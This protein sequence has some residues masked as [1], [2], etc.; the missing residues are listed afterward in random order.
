VGVGLA[1]AQQ[2][3]VDFEG[4][5]LWNQEKSIV[6]VQVEHI[7]SVENLEEILDVPGVDG[8]IVGP[9]DLSGSLGVPGQFQHPDVV[10]A[11]QRIKK[12]TREKNAL[13]GFHVVQPDPASFAEK[14]QEGYRFIAVGLDILYL[15]NACRNTLTACKSKGKPH[16]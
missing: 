6:I 8:F 12:V 1:R 14:E 5:R 2:Y 13:S 16:A 11:L 7:R 10:D 4:Y 9:Y 3:G 15:G